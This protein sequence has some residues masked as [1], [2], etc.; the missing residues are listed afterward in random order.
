MEI[1]IKNDIEKGMEINPEIRVTPLRAT[2]KWPGQTARRIYGGAYNSV[3]CF[4]LI[5]VTKVFNSAD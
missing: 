4:H 5:L 3:I 2:N 1:L